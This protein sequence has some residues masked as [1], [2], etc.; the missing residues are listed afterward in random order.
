MISWGGGSL[1]KSVLFKLPQADVN[2]F[3]KPLGYVV[4]IQTF[5]PL[6]LALR[7][8]YFKTGLYMFP[9]RK[10]SCLSVNKVVLSVS[11][12]KADSLSHHPHQPT[13]VE[14]PQS[15]RSFSQSSPLIPYSF[16]QFWQFAGEN[17]HLSY[18]VQN[19]AQNELG[20]GYYQAKDTDIASPHYEWQLTRTGFWNKTARCNGQ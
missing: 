4:V 18:I 17:E 5:S 8:H 3:N 19:T 20:H 10:G 12:S 14:D 11:I 15:N 7:T 16:P 1:K 2:Y 9:W 13:T 6:C